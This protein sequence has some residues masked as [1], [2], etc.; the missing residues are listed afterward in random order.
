MNKDSVQVDLVLNSM[1]TSTQVYSLSPSN[2]YINTLFHL[3]YCIG[4]CIGESCHFA[5][6]YTTWNTVEIHIGDLHLSFNKL[7]GLS[8]IVVE[9]QFIDL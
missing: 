8:V 3:T 7:Y 9:K 6:L 5:G 2:E 1:S 4:Y